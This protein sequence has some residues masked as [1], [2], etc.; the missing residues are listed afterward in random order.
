MLQWARGNGCPWDRLMGSASETAR[1]RRMES[2]E[3]RIVAGTV[4]AQHES[5]NQSGH[6]VA[7]IV[8]GL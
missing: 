8:E 2:A 1:S 3:L 6:R 4:L 5:T 7:R